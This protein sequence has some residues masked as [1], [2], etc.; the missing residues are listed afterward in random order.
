ML[1][2]VPS[3]P[4]MTPKSLLVAVNITRSRRESVRSSHCPFTIERKVN[5]SL[6]STPCSWSPFRIPVVSALTSERV[7]AK[8]SFSSMGVLSFK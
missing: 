1:S 7:W 2:T 4:L 6:S 5:S 8:T 3:V